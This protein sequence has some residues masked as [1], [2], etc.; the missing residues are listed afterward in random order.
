MNF[1][2]SYPFFPFPWMHTEESKAWRHI[3]TVT[4]K[5]LTNPVS[6][7]LRK[8]GHLKGEKKSRIKK[9]DESP[10]LPPPWPPARCF[11][12]HCLLLPKG[13][14]TKA[15][16]KRWLKGAKKWK[17][18]RGGSMGKMA[19]LKWWHGKMNRKKQF[20]IY[21][22]ATM[23]DVKEAPSPQQQRIRKPNK[24]CHHQSSNTSLLPCT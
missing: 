23:P 20:S 8:K 21:V 1:L 13:E 4:F 10:P 11:C 12:C 6:V 7:P 14:K 19:R 22:P 2:F 5:H 17:G 3:A 9:S 16:C 18:W 24:Q 15:W